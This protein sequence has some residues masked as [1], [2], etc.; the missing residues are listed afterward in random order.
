MNFCTSEVDPGEIVERLRDEVGH[1]LVRR[2]VD[3]DDWVSDAVLDIAAG[4][5]KSWTYSDWHMLLVDLRRTP[6]KLADWL[7]L[8]T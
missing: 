8:N 6:G 3:R 4:N 5:R 2:V 7:D 1:L